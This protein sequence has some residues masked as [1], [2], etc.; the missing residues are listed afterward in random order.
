MVEPDGLSRLW[1]VHFSFLAEGENIPLSC[2]GEKMG[3]KDREN[4]MEIIPFSPVFAREGIT[5]CYSSF[6]R[7]QQ[8]LGGQQ[9][10]CRGEQPLLELVWGQHVGTT[11]RW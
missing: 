3:E 2:P 6:P 11:R 4:Y 5:S 10:G 9:G 8:A 7:S 1:E